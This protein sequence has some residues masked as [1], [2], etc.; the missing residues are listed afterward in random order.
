MRILL[1]LPT[2]LMR[3]LKVRVG[4]EGRRLL[5]LMRALVTRSGQ[6]PVVQPLPE[7][8]LGRPLVLTTDQLNHADLS[9]LVEE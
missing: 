1:N 3:H 2:Q 7:V 5:D 6:T 4:L 8:R 9:A